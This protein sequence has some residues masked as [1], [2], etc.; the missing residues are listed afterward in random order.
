MPTV[1]Q[2]DPKAAYL[3]HQAA[4]D[5]AVRRTL[6]GGRYVLGPE[7]R[8][9][10]QE[11]ARYLG[12]EHA[13]GVASGTDAIELAL[14]ACG[15]ASGDLVATVSHTAVATVA[16]IERCGAVPLLVDVDLATQTLDPGR[17]ELALRNAQGRLRAVVLVHLYGRAA[18]VAQIR[19]L[20]DRHEAVLVED[21][22]QAH[23]AA[24]LGRRLGTWGDA[25]AFSFYP[26]K[27]LGALGDGGSVVTR[28][29][30]TAERIAALREY[31]WRER[32]VSE[33]CGMNSRLDELQAAVLRVKLAHLDADNARR[34][35]IAAAYDAG[36]QDCALQLP[37]PDASHVYHQYVV[38]TPARAE[39]SAHL[40]AR[41]I[42]TLV[43]YPLP[44][45]LQPAYRGRLPVGEGG[46]AASEQC[47]R[48]VLS[49]PM[50][51]QLK[52]AAVDAVID[53]LRSFAQPR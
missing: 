20:C 53:A 49:L 43:H 25:A 36:L 52:P 26:T 38:R 22:A 1:P 29:R 39:L 19:A 34:R 45:H 24:V 10:E 2:C 13:C 5:A 42:G 23:G 35:A 15:I 4:I 16:A 27:N 33:S 51:P 11:F 3:E 17:L 30:G 41:G 32:Y 14:R 44:V 46:L 18:D 12:S 21:C 7:V 37:L 48:E 31:G 8:A 6:D 47:A 28:D 9:F 50:F 40:A